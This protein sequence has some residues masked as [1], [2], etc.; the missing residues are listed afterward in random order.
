MTI[1][2]NKTY[3]IYI[4]I[5]HFFISTSKHVHCHNTN[6]SEHIYKH[7]EAKLTKTFE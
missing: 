5:I 1:I 4:N 2:I 6:N 7:V 3:T